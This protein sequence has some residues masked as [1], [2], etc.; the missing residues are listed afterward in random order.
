MAIK[1]DVDSINYHQ[2]IS[3]KRVKLYYS[4][5]RDMPV[6]D[7]PHYG[8]YDFEEKDSS[9]TVP[10]PYADL[11]LKASPNLFSVKKTA[12]QGYDGM[13][14]NELLKAAEAK[15]YDVKTQSRKKADV[16]EF[17]LKGE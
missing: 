11:L 2:K 7:H 10:K 13:G 12:K 9:F 8:V 3:T 1:K 15:G 4:G 16:L 5:E 6:L 17:L 14:Y